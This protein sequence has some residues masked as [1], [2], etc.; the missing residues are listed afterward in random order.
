MNFHGLATQLLTQARLDVWRLVRFW[1]HLLGAWG[2]GPCA[3]PAARCL[4]GE[5]YLARRGGWGGLK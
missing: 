4:P 5:G 3:V 2:P 1:A